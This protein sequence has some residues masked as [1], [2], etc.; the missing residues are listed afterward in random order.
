MSNKEM[1]AKMDVLSAKIDEMM[2]KM[3]AENPKEDAA[4][5]EESDTNSDTSSESSS[6]DTTDT[7]GEEPA[8][9]KT[10]KLGIMTMIKL[11]GAGK[12]KDKMI[13]MGMSAKDKLKKSLMNNK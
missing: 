2:T 9:S 3:E 1:C 12:M 11:K 13:E 7:S 6:E 4:S 8:D 5:N 10:P